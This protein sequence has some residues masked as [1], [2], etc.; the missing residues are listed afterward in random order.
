MISGNSTIL[1]NGTHNFTGADLRCS[2]KVSG[3][4]TTHVAT[5]DFCANAISSLKS[6]ATWT[7]THSFN[8]ATAIT[9][10]SRTAGD[11]ASYA[12]STA[13]VSTA[14]SSVLNG[15]TWTGN[16]NFTGATLTALTQSSLI[17]DTKVA[18]TAFVILLLIV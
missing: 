6:G 11:N 9:V 16:H 13:F 5:T 4:A 10:P 17:N 7:G 14:I 15:S 1:W 3:T 8:N 12:A 2:T 18:T